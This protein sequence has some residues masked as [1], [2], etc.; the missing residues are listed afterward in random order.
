M[1]RGRSHLPTTHLSG[2]L[3][4][5]LRQTQTGHLHPFSLSK[6]NISS[7]PTLGFSTSDSTFATGMQF[8]NLLGK[9]KEPDCIGP[10]QS[11]RRPLQLKDKTHASQA[12]T[13]V[14]TSQKL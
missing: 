14:T 13:D 2:L 5:L 12:C 4:P 8:E 3:N 11:C 6:Q 9:E 7:F 10:L 1:A